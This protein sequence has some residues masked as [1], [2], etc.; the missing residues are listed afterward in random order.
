MAFRTLEEAKKMKRAYS[1]E[2]NVN[3]RLVDCWKDMNERTIY[4]A[5]AD[6]DTGFDGE[7]VK[8]TFSGAELERFSA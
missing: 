2:F 1:P 5:V 4:L 7:Y 6:S 3:V 8:K